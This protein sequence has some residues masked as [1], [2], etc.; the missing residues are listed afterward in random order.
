MLELNEMNG[1]YRGSPYIQEKIMI[2]ERLVMEKLVK[3]TKFN[4]QKYLV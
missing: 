4:W 1:K 2:A 3:N